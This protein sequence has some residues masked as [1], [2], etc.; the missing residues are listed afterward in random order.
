MLCGEALSTEESYAMLDHAH[1][2][3]LRTWDTAEMYPVPQAAATAG[4]SEELLG[5]WLR[6]RGHRREAHGVVTKV[7]GPGGMPW[8]RGGPVA[9]DAANIVEAA[10]GSLRRLRCEYIDCLLLHW[11]DRCAASVYVCMHDCVL[12]RF[13]SILRPARPPLTLR[14][15]RQ[16]RTPGGGAACA[17]L[18]RRLAGGTPANS[19]L[20]AQ[21][22]CVREHGLVCLTDPG[23]ACAA[24]SV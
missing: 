10:E 16:R 19:S 9:L 20:R 15:T 17:R 3:G 14:N 13:A 22:A 21:P 1:A 12:Y 5:S 8:L 23:C 2:L 24:N 18:A 7:A 4:R 6:S 11:P